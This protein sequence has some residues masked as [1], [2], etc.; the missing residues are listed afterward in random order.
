M[1]RA[2]LNIDSNINQEFFQ[3]QDSRT[4]RIFKI[5]IQGE[6]IALDSALNRVGSAAE[7]FDDLLQSTLSLT[8][9]CFI[10]FC[11]TDDLTDN[12]SW[13]MLTWIPDGCR[14]RDKMLYSSSREDLKKNVGLGFF[15][16]EYAAN[17]IIDINWA[18]YQNY[19][20]KESNSVVLTED[21]RLWQEERVLTYKSLKLKFFFIKIF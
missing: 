6:S 19:L 11:Q 14:V 3:A 21:E 5:K 18:S 2:N 12:L 8:E 10:F 9:A 15:K 7:D 20:K 17:E 4:V 13:L 16:N 1:A